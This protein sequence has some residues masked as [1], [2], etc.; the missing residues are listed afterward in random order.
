[1]RKAIGVILVAS[2]LLGGCMTHMHVVGDGAPMGTTQEERQWYVLW[3]LVPINKVDTAQM[4]MGAANYTIK[5]EQNALDVIINI[6]TSVVTVT[7]RTV[8]VKK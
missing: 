8:T 6:F 5:T 1:M 4:T 2:L 3:G 7:S